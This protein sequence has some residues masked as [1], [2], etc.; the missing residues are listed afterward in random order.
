MKNC[1]LLLGLA[2][3]AG[4]AGIK[5]QN[6]EPTTCPENQPAPEAVEIA[7]SV[8]MSTYDDLEELVVTGV[9]PVVTSDGATTTYS[10][11]DDPG[12]AGITLLDLLRKVPMVSV[13]ANDNIK[14]KGEG[15]YKILVNGKEDPTL[16]ANASQIFKMMP[17]NSVAKIEVITEPGAKYDAEGTGGIINLITIRNQRQDGYNV[18]ANVYA[19]NRMSGGGANARAKIGNIT[20]GANIDYANGRYNPSKTSTKDET[21]FLDPVTG[22]ATSILDH[23]SEQKTKFD[24]IGAGLKL[25]WEPTANDLLSIDL[26]FNKVKGDIADMADQT[27]SYE[28]YDPDQWIFGDPQWTIWNRINARMSNL[29]SSALAS[30]QHNFAG[31]RN[32]LAVSYQFSYGHNE[33]TSLTEA[34]ELRNTWQ[35]PFSANKQLNINREQTVQ[36]DYTNDFN[37]EHHLLETGGKYVGRHNSGFGNLSTGE[38]EAGMLPVDAAATNLTQL[39]DIAALYASYTGTFEKWNAKAGVRYEHTRMGNRYHLSEGE[40]FT[41]NL[42][43]VVPN[44]AIAYSFGAAQN[45]RLAYQMRISRPTMEQV[46][47]YLME[48]SQYLN[49]CGNPDL[50]SE[51]NNNVSLTYTQFGAVLGGNIGIEYSQTDNCISDFIYADGEKLIRSYA[52]LGKKRAAALNGFLSWTIIPRMTLGING[53]VE[54]VDFSSDSPRFSNHGWQGNFGANWNYMLLSGWSFSAYGGMSTRN[55]NLQGYW[56]GYHYYG[57]A[58]NKQ[59]LK[60]R[61]L[62]VGVSMNNFLESEIKYKSY[63]QSLNYRS[64][65]TNYNANWNIGVNLSWNFGSLKQD[66]KRT[67]ASIENN[68]KSSAKGANMMGN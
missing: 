35:I 44:A 25:S 18:G 63:S 36:I 34:E 11:D 60:D 43:D 48:L 64:Y 38:T 27:T 17:A 61:S 2:S 32:Y 30:Y 19:N 54:Y 28:P 59:L 58:V 6:I 49:M 65:S 41:R 62:T 23:W 16:S 39:Q 12:A 37:S 42:D 31:N 67:S 56:P 9:R 40:D 5:A 33:L 4:L 55:L 52:N 53:R 20:M 45:L 3:A 15:N 57:L 1:V 26:S 66:V 21:L 29:S 50:K 13:D 14:L 24:Y 8:A 22:E 10:V 47:P 7:D 46:N 68:D 51:H